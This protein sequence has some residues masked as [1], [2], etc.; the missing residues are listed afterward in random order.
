[1]EVENISNKLNDEDYKKIK[2]DITSIY[3]N[4]E[5]IRRELLDEIDI[6]RNK[7]EEAL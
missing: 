5:E 6:F 4:I 2:N 3:L 1:M 7:V